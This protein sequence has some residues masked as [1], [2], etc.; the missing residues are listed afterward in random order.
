MEVGKTPKGLEKPPLRTSDSKT[1]INAALPDASDKDQNR[2]TGT[3]PKNMIVTKEYALSLFNTPLKSVDTRSLDPKA[4][5]EGMAKLLEDDESILDAMAKNMDSSTIAALTVTTL[6]TA[7]ATMATL[8]YAIRAQNPFA[9]MLMQ[10]GGSG[11]LTEMQEATRNVLETA[12]N[13]IRT[14]TS[15][16]DAEIPLGAAMLSVVV[17]TEKLMLT[18]LQAQNLETNNASALATAFKTG[19]ERIY[20][21]QVDSADAKLKSE[22]TYVGADLTQRRNALLAKYGSTYEEA[23]GWVKKYIETFTRVILVPKLLEKGMIKSEKEYDEYEAAM[24]A[25]AKRQ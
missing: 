5:G 19:N 4:L 10:A 15:A 8:E 14:I 11:Y 20:T 7:F 2:G 3:N 21:A 1:G 22:L 12:Q 13:T 17:A 25:A 18:N 9:E 24:E 23:E 16:G 6:G